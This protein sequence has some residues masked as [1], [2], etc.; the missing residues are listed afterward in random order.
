[1]NCL[2]SDDQVRMDIAHQIATAAACLD[3]LK[4]AGSQEAIEQINKLHAIA[5]CIA[6][7]RAGEIYTPDDV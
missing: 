4:P 2:L 3:S 6:G 1:M 7:E 5:E